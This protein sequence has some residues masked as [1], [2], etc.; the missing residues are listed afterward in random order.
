[1]R[2]DRRLEALSFHYG[3]RLWSGMTSEETVAALAALAGLIQ[4]RRAASRKL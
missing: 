4:M 1:M 2:C 3:N